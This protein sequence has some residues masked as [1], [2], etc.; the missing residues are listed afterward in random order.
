LLL[1]F[2]D[3]EQLP[4]AAGALLQAKDQGASWLRDVRYALPDPGAWVP[5]GGWLLR[6]DAPA[7]RA[8]EVNAL[9]AGYGLYAAE[10]RRS[11]GSLEQYFLALTG[12]PGVNG[13]PVAPANLASAETAPA[14]AAPAAGEQATGGRA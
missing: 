7:E 11:E 8:S 12:S 5:P 13:V 3:A 2:A 6:V 4:R 9:L 10:L 1:G 14:A